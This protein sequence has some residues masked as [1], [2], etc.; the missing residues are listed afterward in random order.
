MT[1]KLPK[2][3]LVGVLP[4]ND[5][6]IEQAVLGEVMIDPVGCEVHIVA[7]PPELFYKDSHQY[8]WKVFREL[9]KENIVIDILTVTQKLRKNGTLENVGGAYYVSQLTNRV[10]GSVYIGEHIAILRELHISRQLAI[11]CQNTANAAHNPTVD[12]F[13]LLTKHRK[14][15]EDIAT[16]QDRQKDKTFGE[17][18]EES[19]SEAKAVEEAVTKGLPVGITTGLYTLD[20][21]TGGWKGGTL[22][23]LAARPAM[24]KTGLAVMLAKSAAKSGVRTAFFSLE[25]KG[26]RLTDRIL[27]S[28]VSIEKEA[29]REGKLHR[30]NWEE[31]ELAKKDLEKYPLHIFDQSRYTMLELRSKVKQIPNIGLIVLDYLQLMNADFTGYK[32]NR[33]QQ[34]AG[35][36]RALK[37]LSLELDIPV[38]ALSQLN[39]SAEKNQG[40]RPSL[41]DLRES[42]A[43]E[44][45]ADIVA[46]IHRAAYYADADTYMNYAGQA[47]IIIAK[48]RDGPVGNH[49]IRHSADFTQWYEMSE[50]LRA[51]KSAVLEPEIKFQEETKIETQPDEKD[52][53]DYF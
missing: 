44:Q 39:R 46:F 52:K 4:R 17:F 34:V 20:K 19:V 48:F 47:E 8:I 7:E 50:G 13:S 43:I 6:S 23:I 38:I 27:M 10:S 42:G 12:A 3:L 49:F 31:I 28:H 16:S 35:I 53:P 51:K 32:E 40:A 41:S 37:S 25:D 45:D 5:E 14:T 15:V 18:L 33:E 22:V 11:E 24:G 1:D 29:Y 2:H 26:V 30:M 36:S 9:L 21:A